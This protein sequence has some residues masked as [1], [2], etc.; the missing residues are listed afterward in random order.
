MIGYTVNLTRLCHKYYTYNPIGTL[1]IYITYNDIPHIL[2]TT[3]ILYE[4]IQFFNLQSKIISSCR[5]TLNYII[6]SVII[7]DLGSDD[8]NKFHS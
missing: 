5:L 4:W 7:I 3:Y 8:E 1:Y 2:I 6:V